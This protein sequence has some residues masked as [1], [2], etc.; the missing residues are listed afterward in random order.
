MKT[1]N[2]PKVIVVLM[3]LL[4]V[5]AIDLTVNIMHLG[6]YEERKEAGN[7][8]WEQVEERI[9]E[10]EERMDKLEKEGE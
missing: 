3:A 7:A 10:I 6:S 9:I 5:V 8:R 4:V 2:T 1:D